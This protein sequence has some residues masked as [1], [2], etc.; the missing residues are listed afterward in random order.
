LKRFPQ[1]SLG[2]PDPVSRNFLSFLSNL[3]THASSFDFA[4]EKNIKESIFGVVESIR[5]HYLYVLLHVT[6]VLVIYRCIIW[7]LPPCFFYWHLCAS[8]Y[9][10]SYTTSL[11]ANHFFLPT[12]VSLLVWSCYVYFESGCSY[13]TSL[14]NSYFFPW[15]LL[16]HNVYSYVCVHVWSLYYARLTRP[17]YFSKWSIMRTTIRTSNINNNDDRKCWN[18][19][20]W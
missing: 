8:T 4:W 11:A 14:S 15:M 16:S 6:L 1:L 17:C 7:L 19:S 20:S 5:R 2:V 13:T 18:L 3:R 9:D 12:I 10:R